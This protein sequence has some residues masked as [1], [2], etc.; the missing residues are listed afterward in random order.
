MSARADLCGGRPA[1]VVP[2]ATS[3][4]E[5]RVPAISQAMLTFEESS[6]FLGGA[7]WAAPLIFSTKARC[8]AFLLSKDLV[9]GSEGSQVAPASFSTKAWYA[10]FLLLKDVIIGVV[11]FITP[12]WLLCIRRL[13]E[14][15][16][17]VWNRNRLVRALGVRCRRLLKHDVD[18][19]SGR[20][21]DDNMF[22]GQHL[23][24]LFVAG[25]SDVVRNLHSHE[26]VFAKGA[27]GVRRPDH[28]RRCLAD[29]RERPD[30]H[31]F[32]PLPSRDLS[33]NGLEIHVG[34]DS[35]NG[36][37]RPIR[38]LDRRKGDVH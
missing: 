33:L 12:S 24:D 34:T 36:N 26:I 11:G 5:T 37:A 28:H 32:A 7:D 9:I 13:A 8:A 35:V 31:A 2:T 1:M 4:T 3:S 30:E 17:R 16:S 20:N 29:S 15:Y 21:A 6:P 22:H 25:V 10:A 14:T 18:F 19:R 27:V 23:H 38:K